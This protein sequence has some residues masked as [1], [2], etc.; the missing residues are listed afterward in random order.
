MAQA[1][2]LKS[3]GGGVIFIEKKAPAARY[4]AA[5]ELVKSDKSRVAISP[6]ESA[7]GKIHSSHRACQIQ[8]PFS[9]EES[10]CA[11]IHNSNRACQVPAK[12]AVRSK[13]MTFRQKWFENHRFG[14][15][16]RRNESCGLSR[17]IWVTFE[18]KDV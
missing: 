9:L 18:T 10:A 5:T 16:F 6:E 8:W 13:N 7:C 11:K 15:K 3:P 14:L 4:M 2:M 1:K 17:P 12:V